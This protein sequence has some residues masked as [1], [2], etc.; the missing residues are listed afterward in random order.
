MVESLRCL[1]VTFAWGGVLS[2]AWALEAPPTAVDKPSEDQSPASAG[3]DAAATAEESDA[4]AEIVW[5]DDYLAAVAEAREQGRMLLIHF[6]G[7]ED[8]AASKRFREETL[9][10]A[11]VIKKLGD[12]VCV[13]VPLG[14]E[15]EIAGEKIRLLKHHSFGEMVGRPGVAIVDYRHREAEF[16]GHVVSTFPLTRELFYT[17]T[18][19]QVILD[20][21]PGELTQRTIIY[22]V[23]T[24]PDRPKS[25]DGSL[26]TALTEEAESHSKHQARIRNQGHHQWGSRF[27][28]INRKLPRGLMAVEVCAES[29]PGENLV[30]A[31]V[32]CVRCWRFSSGHWSK[33]R[34]PHREYGYDI[35]RGRN[36]IWYATGIF[37]AGG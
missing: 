18:K 27:H 24:H 13:R 16:Y 26:N 1:V 14:V 25:T 37:G 33:V 30:E 31:A 34:A 6:V 19:M 29:W 28:R 7:P 36:G 20:L 35:R 3:A 8:D 5:L 4:S 11:G 17:P 9:S 22:A 21:P 2:S 10:D 23:R 12:Y 15:V 32:E